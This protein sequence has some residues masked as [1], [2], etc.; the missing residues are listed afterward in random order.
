MNAH[1]VGYDT[2][3]NPLIEWLPLIAFFVVYRFF[4][5]YSA[6]AALM[7]ACVLQLLVHRAR[8][9]RYKS[10]HVVTLG[11]VLALGSATLLL[12][13]KRFIQWKPTVLLGT[14]AVAFLGSMVIGDKPLVRRMLE[15]AFGE[16][17]Q[18]TRRAWSVLNVLW[19]LFLA[20]L[21]YLNIYVARNFTESVWFN[22]HFFGV[23]L[24]LLAFMIPQVLWLS[25]KVK[26]APVKVGP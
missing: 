23:T 1:A 3:M 24:A 15:S 17:P 18:I 2:R 14:A 12:H 10:M 16:P 25:G 13:D 9:G 7:A 4:G 6:T 5:L 19:A 21:A 26:S 20:L 22:F 11:V 8:T